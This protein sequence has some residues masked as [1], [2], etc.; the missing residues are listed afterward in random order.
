MSAWTD[1][2]AKWFFDD[3]AVGAGKQYVFTNHYKSTTDTWLTARYTSTTGVITYVD[4]SSLP[5]SGGV[6]TQ[7]SK[8]VAPP[9]GTASITIFH[10]INKVGT[11]TTDA[12]SFIESDGSAPDAFDKGYVSITIDDGW[13]NQYTTGLPILTAS[14]LKASFFIIS[15]EVQNAD[16]QGP[17]HEYMNVTQMLDI[18]SKGHEVSSH[19]KT[20][21]SLIALSAAAAQDE[22]T[23]SRTALQSLGVNPADTFVYPFGDQNASVVQYVKNAGYIGARGVEAGFNTKASNKYILQSQNVGLATTVDQ[24]KAWV[25]AAA[26]NKTWLILTFHLIDTSNDEYSVT[27]ANF[28][29]IIDYLKTKGI[30]VIT[31]KQGLQMMP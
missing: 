20:H 26:A 12:F 27:P 9:I 1:G 30:A 29:A 13:T 11:L 22:I 23:G 10:L 3:V 31:M 2:D 24:V 18:Q 8:I 15:D 5:S 25:D 19:T 6:W 7:I 17:T 4:I 16:S 14:G 21:P 28:Q